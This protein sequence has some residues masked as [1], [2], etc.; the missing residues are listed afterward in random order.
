MQ[1]NT[2]IAVERKCIHTV[3]KFVV[4]PKYILD[5]SIL[6][7]VT[8]SQR[9]AVFLAKSKLSQSHIMHILKAVALERYHQKPSLQVH[10][11][12][13]IAVVRRPTV[14]KAMCAVVVNLLKRLLLGH[15]AVVKRPMTTPLN[16]A[17]I[18]R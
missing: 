9:I 16:N 6:A 10:I 15:T 1:V 4:V 18:T 8:K 14:T 7:V 5:H 11:P 17:V 3:H 12:I 13:T 2:S